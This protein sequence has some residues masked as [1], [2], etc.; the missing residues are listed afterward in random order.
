MVSLTALSVRTRVWCF[1][2]EDTL[3][4][5]TG[6]RFMWGTSLVAAVIFSGNSSS[7]STKRTLEDQPRLLARLVRCSGSAEDN[8]RSDTTWRSSCT[9]LTLSVWVRP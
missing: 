3:R 4:P 7:V 9:N 8:S 6:I 1:I 5:Y 2:M